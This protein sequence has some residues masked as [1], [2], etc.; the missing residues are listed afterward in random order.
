MTFITLFRFLYWYII[1]I[2]HYPR[3]HWRWQKIYPSSTDFPYQENIPSSVNHVCKCS[4]HDCQIGATDDVFVILC[5]GVWE[6]GKE[7]ERKGEKDREELPTQSVPWLPC[8]TW[9][10]TLLT[11]PNPR[12]IGWVPFLSLL[13]LSIV[14]IY[15]SPLL[16]SRFWLGLVYQANCFLWLRTCSGFVTKKSVC[17]FQCYLNNLITVY[18]TSFYKRPLKTRLKIFLYHLR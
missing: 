2:S 5:V 8:I 7:W 9:C 1:F 11:T 13:Q 12:S 15:N 17:F 6:W 14:L 18:L 10:L 4:R 16:L 3:N